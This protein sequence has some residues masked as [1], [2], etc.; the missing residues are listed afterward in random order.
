VTGV[1]LRLLIVVG[2]GLASALLAHRAAARSERAGLALGAIGL[3]LV[4]LQ[5]ADPR[6]DL[7]HHV[8]LPT[9]LW[10]D[11]LLAPGALL[12]G[13]AWARARRSSR[14]R[15]LT[16]LLSLGYAFFA[17]HD[18]LFVLATARDN[19]APPTVDAKG[20]VRQR[21]DRNCLPASA[22]TVLR[23]WGVDAGDGELALDMHTSY[24][25]TLEHRA[26]ASLRARGFDA[27]LV[28]T[29]WEELRAIDHP[30]VL[31]VKLLNQTPHA[32]ALVGLS[33]ERVFIA[34]PLLGEQGFEPAMFEAWKPWDGVAILVG[35]D[36]D[37][38]LGR[39]DRHAV[40]RRARDVL[41]VDGDETFD[42]SLEARVRAFQ[43]EKGLPEI[44]RLEPK[45][46]LALW[47]LAGREPSLA[48]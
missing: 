37:H 1:I 35:K 31:M 3:L 12:V 27:A 47:A 32:V 43:R 25:G 41:K 9:G 19:L 2:V 24:Y 5:W 42:E 48:R 26:L 36:I 22:A 38:D 29:T 4:L 21:N 30:C 46:L 20:V 34:E 15:V 33:K 8:W 13:V 11:L 23:R 28:R 6:W 10:R 44:G 45:T 39:G 7:D 40:V 17:L 14:E 16:A 18:P